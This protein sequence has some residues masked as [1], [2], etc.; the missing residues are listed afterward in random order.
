LHV[1]AATLP[2]YAGGARFVDLAPVADPTLVPQVTATACGVREV[3]GR[4]LLATL[5]DAL[6]LSEL[7]LVLDNCEHLVA[8]CAALADA[9]LQTCPQVRIL[10]TSREALGVAGETVWQVLPL[11]VGGAAA[12]VATGDVAPGAEPGVE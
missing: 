2:Q 10:A 11:P 5:A 7:L 1:A 12:A 8:A 6:R 9:L 4:P 3:P